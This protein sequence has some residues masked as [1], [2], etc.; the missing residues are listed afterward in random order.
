ML[1]CP[2]VRCTAVCPL[3]PMRVCVMHPPCKYSGMH[4]LWSSPAF[5]SELVQ[6]RALT[7][8]QMRRTHR[9]T[10]PPRSG[11][12]GTARDGSGRLGTARDGTGRYGTA[13]DGRDGPGRVGTGG[14]E[15]APMGS[16]RGGRRGSEGIIYMM[17][18]CTP[19]KA[20][21]PP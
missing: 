1:D 20:P 17:Y 10:G 13:R 21:V 3:C 2:H 9:R 5:H 6:G 11:R 18:S 15:G 7:T 19:Q 4:G 8:M 16:R 14:S 12:L